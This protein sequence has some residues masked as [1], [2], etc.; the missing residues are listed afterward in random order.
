M[1]DS[2]GVVQI[3]YDVVVG[4]QFRFDVDGV[5]AS[6][7]YCLGL[8]GVIFD[9][10]DDDNNILDMSVSLTNLTLS[11]SGGK[12]TITGTVQGTFEDDDHHTG[13]VYTQVILIA[14]LSGSFSQPT[15]ANPPGFASGGTSESITVND[16]S[17]LFTGLLSGF[18]MSYSDSKD[19][20]VNQIGANITVYPNGSS[21]NLGGTCVLEESSKTKASELTLYGA[22]F[23]DSNASPVFEVIPYQTQAGVTQPTVTFDNEVTMAQAVLVGFN[24]QYP[25]TDT[26]KVKKMGVS[27]NYFFAPGAPANGGLQPDMKTFMFNNPQPFMWDDEGNNLDGSTSYAKYVVIGAVKQQS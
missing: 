10:G 15:M 6:N 19:Q 18:S 4:G 7:S 27:Y 2:F 16:P 11:V 14:S 9:F 21:A 23:A 24:A 25:G 20:S 22:L 8:A 1:A 12:S 17:P 26:H 3:A 5:V 13:Q